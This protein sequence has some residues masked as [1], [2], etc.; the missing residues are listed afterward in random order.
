MKLIN[1]YGFQILKL[2]LKYKFILLI[3]FFVLLGIAA[4]SQPN[5]DL[6]LI[7]QQK[8][9]NE[10]YTN[11]RIVKF[12]IIDSNNK[13]LIYN[14]VT[15]VFS[16]L[17]FGYQKLISPQISAECLYSPS[18]SEYSRQLIRRY[19]IIKGIIYSS[20]RIMRCDRISATTISPV[21][22]NEKDGKVYESTER[23]S[24]S[25]KKNKE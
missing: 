24:L 4:N 20:D 9:E 15:L 1:L 23:Y 8:F 6:K 22:R 10:I 13:I 14:P 17:M 16:C 18:C 11:Q 3:L 19:G 25:I 7:K 2:R 21:S 5:L 12:G